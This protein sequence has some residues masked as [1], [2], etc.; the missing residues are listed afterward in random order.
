MAP[1]ASERQYGANRPGERG[2]EVAAAV[3]VDGLGQILDL[4]GGGDQAEVVPDPLHQRAGDGDRTLERVHGRLV[5]DLV[6]DRRQQAVLRRHLLGAGIDQHEIAGAVGVLGLAGGQTRL[7]EGGGLLVTE[8]AGDGH[9]GQHATRTGPRRTPADEDL[10]SGSIDSGIFMSSAMAAIPGQRVQ[11]HQQGAGGVGRLRDVQAAVDAAGHVPDDPGVHV[12]EHQVAG[13]GL[14]P[15]TLDVVEDPA[16][17]R[18]REIGGQR[19]SDLV[20]VPL[21]AAA[22]S[23][24]LLADGVGSGVLPDDGVVDGLPRG[25][26]PHHRGFPLIG[27]ADRDDVGR[28]QVRLGQRAG[29]HRA[30]VLPDLDGIMFH[31][32]GFREDLLVF[33]LV[34]RD[35]A[36]LVVEDHAPR[37]RGALV[38]RCYVLL[39]HLASNPFIT[40]D[41]DVK[42]REG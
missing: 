27:D 5:A 16:H 30:D 14:F 24:Q 10:I 26:V 7:P 40:G 2:N 11:I 31:P 38:D 42:F 34:D 19:Q 4:R 1:R 37:G 8:D 22:E 21:G 28:G 41:I 15:G 23:A 33:L 18:S 12:A 17:L 6:A 32:A 20:L 3:V 29:R 35:D 39:T 9:T 13:L 25:L 36:A